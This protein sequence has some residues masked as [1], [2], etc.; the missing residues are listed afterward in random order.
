[1]GIALK[2]DDGGTR[3]AEAMMGAMLARFLTLSDSEHA[4]LQPLLQPALKNWNGI[5]VGDVR[6]AGALS[7]L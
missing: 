3:A 7:A 4:A 6:R 5:H 1:L 2:C